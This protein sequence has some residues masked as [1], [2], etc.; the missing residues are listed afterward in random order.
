MQHC[1]QII[2]YVLDII[3]WKEYKEKYLTGKK[4]FPSGKS[5]VTKQTKFPYSPFRKQM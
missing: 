4:I 2:L 1:H 3:F 5:Q